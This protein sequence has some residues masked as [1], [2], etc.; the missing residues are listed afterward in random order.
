MQNYKQQ[1]LEEIMTILNNGGDADELV[2]NFLKEVD[3]ITAKEITEVAQALEDRGIFSN[4]CHHVHVEQKLFDLINNKVEGGGIDSFPA[5]HPINSYL[6]ENKLIKVLAE[7][8]VEL[9]QNENSFSELKSDW[10]LIAKQYLSIIIHYTRKENQL[11]PFL[12]KKGFSHPS[13][14]MWSV[15]D[16][17]RELVKQFSG[18]VKDNNENV[19]RNILQHLSREAFEMTMKEE[20]ILLPT[21]DRLLDENDWEQIRLGE[22][23]I[24]WMIPDPPKAW[25]EGVNEEPQAHPHAQM[26]S[27]ADAGVGSERS[28]VGAVNLDTGAITPDEINL[29][30]KHLPF[31]VTY[32]DEF[33][34]V[35]YFNKGEERVFPRSPGIIGREVRLCHPPKSVHVVQQIVTAFRSGEKDSAEFWIDMGGKMIFIQYFAVRDDAGNYRGVIE[36]TSDITHVRSLEG[37]QRLLDWELTK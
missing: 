13:T 3:S 7:R 22:D 8:S 5:G 37:E 32:V 9:M 12:E 34:K 28:L 24:G 26:M 4:Q 23:E 29:I 17:I 10:L 33:D 11:F 6:E 2:E 19:A 27:M 14:V 36:V 25:K 35:R 16:R 20:K 1:K 21:A 18:A 15:H 30:F 31:D